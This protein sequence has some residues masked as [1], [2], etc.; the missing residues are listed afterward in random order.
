[1]RSLY[2][3][4]FTSRKL[5]EEA[6]RVSLRGKLMRNLYEETFADNVFPP[7]Q[8]PT[9]DECEKKGHFQGTAQKLQHFEVSFCKG[10]PYKSHMP[11][12]IWYHF[13]FIFLRTMFGPV[14]RTMLQN[15]PENVRC[16]LARTPSS[17]LQKKKSDTDIRKFP[18]KHCPAPKNIV[19]KTENIVRKRSEKKVKKK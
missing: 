11:P 13:F 14:P 5:Y 1:M 17:V 7:A 19:R 4:A 2:E 3:E 15:L 12:S 16:K 9:G 10:F 8:I 18:Q 6:L